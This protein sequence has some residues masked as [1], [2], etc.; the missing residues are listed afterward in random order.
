MKTETE[1]ASIRLFGLEKEFNARFVSP[2]RSSLEHRTLLDTIRHATMWK[3]SAL[4]II[5]KRIEGADAYFHTESEL[6]EIDDEIYMA[7]SGEDSTQTLIFIDQVKHSAEFVFGMIR[8]RGRMEIPGPLGFDG[9]ALDYLTFSLVHRPI[10]RYL[11]YAVRNDEFALFLHLERYIQKY[12]SS[13]FTDDATLDMRVL[14]KPSADGKLFD[15][16][17]RWEVDTLYQRIRRQ[18]QPVG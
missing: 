18:T 2:F 4:E 6:A 11:F 12:G 10:R 17:K 3:M 15:K 8:A 7:T 14:Y 1:R 16:D 5:K 9:T 13:L